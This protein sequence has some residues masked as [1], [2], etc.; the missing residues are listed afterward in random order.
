M[1]ASESSA[2]PKGSQTLLYV[3]RRRLKHDGQGR[4]KPLLELGL[5]IAKA[6]QVKILGLSIRLTDPRV[7]LGDKVT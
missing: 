7:V 1:I 3:A 4:T 5:S 6:A 2:V